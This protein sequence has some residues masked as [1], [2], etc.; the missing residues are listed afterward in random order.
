[1]SG[2][3]TGSAGGSDGHCDGDA[4]GLV[5]GEVGLSLRQCVD[6]VRD[7]GGLAT[8]ETRHLGVGGG[9]VP[10]GEHGR[11]PGHLESLVTAMNPS[12]R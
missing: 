3:L 4:H 11:L 8:G 2:E 7:D 9:Q 5:F 10:K 1:L 6:V 12:A